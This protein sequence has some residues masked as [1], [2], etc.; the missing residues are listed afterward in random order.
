MDLPFPSK[1]ISDLGSASKQ[2]RGTTKRAS[3]VRLRDS[4]TDSL[5]GSQRGGLEAY[6]GSAPVASKVK[7]LAP[8]VYDRRVVDYTALGDSVTQDWST[9]TPS[10]QDA[11]NVVTD[12]LGNVYAT[13]GNG[14]VKYNA[15]G[16][17]QWKIAF[18]AVEPGSTVRAL[19]VD[20][21][22][23]VFA[24]VSAGSDPKKAKLWCYEQLEDNK[25]NLLW[26][27]T[28][29][30][31]TEAIK[32]VGLTL[33]AAQNDTLKWKSRMALYTGLGVTNPTLSRAWDLAAYPV[34]DV[35]V[36]PKDST[37]ACMH[38]PNTARGAD[39]RSPETTGPL[40]D[41]TIQDI[42][43][44][45]TQSRLWSWHSSMDVDGNDTNNSGY[46]DGD[47]I[48]VW[49]DKSGNGRNWVV[50]PDI[51]GSPQTGPILRKEAIAGRD[52]L[53]FNGTDCVMVGERGVSTLFAH[54]QLNRTTLPLYARHQFCVIYVIRTPMDTTT[55]VL[56]SITP[57]N[58]TAGYDKERVLYTNTTFNA[59]TTAASGNVL[60]YEESNGTNA[61]H[62]RASGGNTTPLP[63]CFDA[64]GLMVVTWICDHGY[65]DVTGTP[66]RS[67][68]RINGR[69]VDRWQ[70]LTG[71]E[72]LESPVLG[73]SVYPNG[74]TAGTR[75]QGDILE[76]IVLCDSYDTGFGQTT[77][78][79]QRQLVVG[80][81]YPGLAGVG[82][83]WGSGSNTEL[84][85][86]EGFAAH[87]RGVAHKL[88]TANAAILDALA[89]GN[90]A[91]TIT[92]DGHVYT[93]RAA[94]TTVADEVKIGASAF[95]TL[96]NL[97]HAIN[98]TGTP[99]TDYGSSTA[100]HASVWSPGVL[101]NGNTAGRPDLLVQRR[102]GRNSSTFGT[103]E[104][105]G[106]ARFAWLNGANSVTS[107]N[108]ATRNAG[109]YPHPF[110][111]YRTAQS[112]GGP[113]RSAGVGVG[114]W[115][116][117]LNSPYGILS[118]WDPSNGKLRAALC[119]D[120][121]NYTALGFGGLGY[122]VRWSS[123]ADI[124]CCGPRQALVS[125]ISVSADNIDVR[126]V[127]WDPSGT[128]VQPFF[129]TDG[130]TATSSWSSAPGA[131]T[132]H[133]P[134]MA[135]DHW[136]NLYVPISVAGISAK[137]YRRIAPSNALDSALIYS[138]TNITDDPAGYAIALDPR[139]P[140]LPSTFT[141]PRAERFFLG[142]PKP[143]SSN[144][145]ALYS[146]REMS[147]AGNG[148]NP[149]VMELVA[150][151]GTG[152][153]KIN[154]G[155]AATAIDAAAFDTGARFV[156]CAALKGALYWVDGTRNYVYDPR[157]NVAGRW[158]ARSS[159][160]IPPYA[161]LIE[162]IGSRLCIGGFLNNRAGLAL[163]EYGDGYGWDFDPPGNSPLTIAAIDSQN[164]DLGDFPDVVTC[165]ASWKD[166]LALV[167]GNRS[168][169]IIRGDP[170]QGG[171][172]DELVKDIGIAFG[173]A[174]CFTPD[175]RFWWVTPEAEF[176]SMAIGETPQ[177]LSGRIQRRFSNSLDFSTA[178]PELV[179]DPES[180]SIRII[181]CVLG[182]PSALYT[183]WTY[184]LDTGEIVGPIWPDTY[185]NTNVQPTCAALMDGD[186]PLDRVLVCGGGV[187]DVWQFSRTA[188][189]DAGSRIASEVFLH[190]PVEGK[191]PTRLAFSNLN[192]VLGIN[193]YGAQYEFYASNDPDDFGLPRV[194]GAL[195]IGRNRLSRVRHSGGYCGL[196]IKGAETPQ[197]W[198]FVEASVDAE[199]AMEG[200]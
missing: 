51:G 100:R 15:D 153:Y 173:R 194:A 68:L 109:H 31:F 8:L 135:V 133:Y 114:S 66:T 183:H 148:A 57:V 55:R 54:R 107:R 75:F 189:S 167:G 47:A 38:E 33:Y 18:P 161:M 184:E 20:D 143:T 62:G 151:I 166:D 110:F 159:G 16:V 44:A 84:E 26:E 126:K 5:T 35:D 13:D 30:W 199:R 97:H 56:E 139:W 115:P 162:R 89:A 90:A 58:S 87:L 63:G 52:S 142:T 146:I 42:L 141:L 121:P 78:F 59:G 198:S 182:S 127:I 130:S 43:G 177:R 74:S 71:F 27:L 103:T 154:K 36:S 4:W 108:G 106:G 132:Y 99:G 91:D 73:F 96:L 34:N 145:V 124:Y 2:E 157:N 105:T 140:D 67:L 102:D 136:E 53:F 1:G 147:V 149:R 95:A 61:P 21:E 14:V 180:R 60:L 175:G 39:P 94:P 80:P 82:S 193:Q 69:P 179:Y 138:V 200:I 125:T 168:I 24:G 164:A 174:R 28:P 192:V 131:L 45:N 197:K 155:G 93:L 185:A 169:S 170:A 9:A 83:A 22:L 123:Q 128:A 195:T 134:R 187:G 49:T 111:L 50:S 77:P 150:V 112:P 11:L 19:A 10:I 101:E 3:N 85:K 178:R 29:G 76:R 25:T 88:P 86:L 117:A 191:T 48:E 186:G 6:S 129:V 23:R 196:L 32:V 113:P 144:N 190:M 116:S 137:V 163:S 79:V 46:Q 176:Y 122:G 158:R 165:I 65:D 104:S 160:Q 81:S 37:V 188:V 70:S 172:F 118:I 17:Q 7:R 41:M 156:D 181:Q 120:G 40:E 171:R 12:S 92:I 72:T 64:D 152:L 119:T 98:G